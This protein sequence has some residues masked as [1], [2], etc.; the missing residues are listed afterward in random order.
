MIEKSWY[1]AHEESSLKI[2]KFAVYQKYCHQCSTTRL[3]SITAENIAIFMLT[4]VRTSNLMLHF[5]FAIDIT[6]HDDGIG[7]FYNFTWERT[8]LCYLSEDVH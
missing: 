4:A 8:Y 5:C 7:N 2:G 3:H 6:L 1:L